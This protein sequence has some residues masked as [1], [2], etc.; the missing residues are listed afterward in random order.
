MTRPETSNGNSGLK[1][2]SETPNIEISQYT[3][4]EMELYIDRQFK[5]E[6]ISQGDQTENSERKNLIKDRICELA[7]GSFHNAQWGIDKVKEIFEDDDH[8][9]LDKFIK[10]IGLN[11][12]SLMREELSKMQKD[13]SVQEI[14]E[15][16]ELLIWIEY[17]RYYFQV[18]DLSPILVRPF[19]Q[20]TCCQSSR[21]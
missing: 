13:L 21:A 1:M 17:G 5:D 7:H 15:L 18:D 6:E 3:G 11:A 12:D 16:N 8:E 4:S 20:L 14:E 19:S 2:R 9:E 10:G